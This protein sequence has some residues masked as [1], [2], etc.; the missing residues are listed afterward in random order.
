MERAVKIPKGYI[1]DGN[2]S[3][4]CGIPEHIKQEVW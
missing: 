4:R 3:P 2:F 1:D